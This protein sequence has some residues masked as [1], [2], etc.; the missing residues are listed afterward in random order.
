MGGNLR[1]AAVTDQAADSAS[2]EPGERRIPLPYLI[3]PIVVLSLTGTVADILGPNLI[4]E[5]PQL[6]MFLNPRNR[7]MILAAATVDVVPFFVIGFLRLVLSDPIGFVLGRQYGEAALKWAGE[8]MGDEG[9]FVRRLERIFGKAAPII[10][11]VAP[12]LYMCLLAGASG[13]KVRVFVALN[14]TGTIAR[15][16]LF[17]ALGHAFRDELLDVVDWIGRNQKWLI[18]ASIVVVAIQSTRS[19]KRGTLETPSEIEREIERAEAELE[20]E[21]DHPRD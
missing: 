4:V 2:G 11:L 13:M 14:V 9:R 20:S 17:R 3:T 18:F 21:A 6:Q 12:N 1:C 10:I 7:Y 8:K 16:V 19:R 15:L 5:H